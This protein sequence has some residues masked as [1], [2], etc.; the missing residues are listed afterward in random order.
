ML[1]RLFALM[2]LWV[3]LTGAIVIAIILFTRALHGHG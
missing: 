1:V 2:T 3:W